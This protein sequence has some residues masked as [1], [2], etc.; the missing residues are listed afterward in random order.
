MCNEISYMKV[1][2]DYTTYLVIWSAAKNCYKRGRRRSGGSPGP[3]VIFLIVQFGIYSS[4]P[5]SEEK[6]V[7][8]GPQG[9]DR[10]HLV[11]P[12]GVKLRAWEK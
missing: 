8:G 11:D 12:S 6:I 7:V 3:G 9:Y 10:R 2:K 5:Y 1:R 4:S